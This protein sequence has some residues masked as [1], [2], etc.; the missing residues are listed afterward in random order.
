VQHI[1]AAGALL[2]KVDQ[3]VAVQ[4]VKAGVQP[5][6]A[7]QRAHRKAAPKVLRKALQKAEAKALPK[8]LQRVPQKAAQKQQVK[9]LQKPEA[10]QLQKA[11]GAAQKPQAVKAAAQ[12]RQPHPVADVIPAVDAAARAAVNSPWYA[13]IQCFYM[14]PFRYCRNGF[15]HS[16]LATSTQTFSKPN[17][18]ICYG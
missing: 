4:P 1:K 14:Y 2:E 8:A 15:F 13:C 9:G 18:L 17:T 7:L 10:K 11:A 12:A 5:Q 6:K 3:T 16:A